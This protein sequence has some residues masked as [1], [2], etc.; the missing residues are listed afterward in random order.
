MRLNTELHLN[1]ER[2]PVWTKTVDKN[3]PA[4]REPHAGEDSTEQRLDN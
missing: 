4:E 3:Q 2:K 1:T